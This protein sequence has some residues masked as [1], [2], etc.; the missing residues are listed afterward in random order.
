MHRRPPLPC[1]KPASTA[2]V[3]LVLDRVRIAGF[4]SFAEATVD[5]R[6][7]NVLVGAN[8]SGK[9]N[10]IQAF[11]L[12]G[13]IVTEHLQ[14]QTAQWGG[15]SRLLHRGTSPSAA[16]ELNVVFGQ[17]QYS[18]RL[19]PTQGDDLYFEHERV[20][21]QGPGHNKPFTVDL[22]QG[23]RETGL[24]AEARKYPG[25][26]AAWALSTMNRWVVHHFHDT[27]AQAPVK[28]R[29][30]IGDDK[31]LRPNA[32]NLAAFLFRL[33]SS[34]P[35][36]F[37]RIVE[38]IRLVAPFFEAFDLA[39]DR[40][41]EQLIQLEWRQRASDAYFNAHALSDGTLRFMCLATLLLQP[42]PPGLILIDEPELGLHPYALRQLADLMAASP[43]QLIVSTQSVTLLNWVSLDDVL[44][45]E[46][47]SGAS[48]V[49]RLDAGTL[50][51]W[52]D[53]YSLGELWEKNL[54]GGGPSWQ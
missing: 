21:Y 48:S 45:V 8:G 46:Q 30:E 29:A 4:R 41:N 6:R 23:H 14:V 3:P 17:N 37:H 20:A 2:T 22:G 44:V 13:S 36:H 27:S 50:A 39:P 52:L 12:L 51:G 19:A 15:A 18:V 32:S 1:V 28:L 43:S 11:T 10:F 7:L 38:A 34:H 26:A 25:K 49:D 54:L 53:D 47:R 40:H 33:Q 9:S 42:D 31:A 5:L 24:E 16:I 35:A